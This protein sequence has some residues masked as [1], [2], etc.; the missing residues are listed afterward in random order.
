MRKQKRSVAEATFKEAGGLGGK[1]VALS[2][3]G[4]NRTI[5]ENEKDP[6]VHPESP[7]NNPSLH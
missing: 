6:T 4:V 2:E 3:D 1:M 5:H 7:R